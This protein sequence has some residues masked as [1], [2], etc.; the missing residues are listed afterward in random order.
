MKILVLGGNRFFGK[1]LVG[2]LAEAGHDV[3]VLNRQ[4]LDDGF[5]E[6]VR[7]LKCDRTD[8]AALA[9]AVD[10]THW[11][12]VYDQ[13]CYEAKDARAACEIFEGHTPRYIFTSSLSVYGEG[14]GLKESD[15]DWRQFDAGP[16]V[17]AS[18]NYPQAKRQC[19]R[20]FFSR[21][22]FAVTAIRF[23]IVTGPDDY[24][25]RLKWHVDRVAAGQPIYLPAISAKM[26]MIH[27][28]D[29]GLTLAKLA[30]SPRVQG[31]L[32]VCSPEPIA[33][34]DLISQ[35]ETLT[36]RKADLV[37]APTD[38]ADSPFGITGDWFMDV[39]KLSSY[40]LV[41]REIREWLPSLLRA[42]R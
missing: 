27:S 21:A 5:G 41:C 26:S 24:T 25:K 34:R 35:I 17:E 7:R 19:E 12:L 40:G 10:S 4:N 31:P 18:K 13:I 8:K 9:R 38:D 23:P 16:D 37:S 32:N 33:L 6:R 15:F 28:D 29:A 36:G 14:A 1:K 11:D 42:I 20:E 3:M 30:A 22:S 2:H 39:S